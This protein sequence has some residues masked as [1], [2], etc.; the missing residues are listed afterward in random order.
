M[1]S[2]RSFFG[3]KTETDKLIKI[4]KKKT[5]KISYT[6]NISACCRELASFSHVCHQ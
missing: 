5:G 1:T 6:T 4:K 3:M 2:K